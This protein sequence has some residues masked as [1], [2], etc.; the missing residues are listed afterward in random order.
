MVYFASDKS[1][2]RSVLPLKAI[3]K[4]QNQHCHETKLLAMV[5]FLV[6]DFKGKISKENLLEFFIENKPCYLYTCKI[7]EGENNSYNK[8]RFAKI[9]KK[10]YIKNI[11]DA[12]KQALEEM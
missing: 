12:I 3:G 8:T 4:K 9:I 7:L 11:G 6:P 5:Y 10:E 1:D 2:I